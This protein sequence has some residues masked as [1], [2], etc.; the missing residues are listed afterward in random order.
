VCIV[1]LAVQ[2]GTA[3]AV[4]AIKMSAKLPTGELHGSRVRRGG[5]PVARRVS[6]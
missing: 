2:A 1:L 3:G 6:A 4:K 5:A